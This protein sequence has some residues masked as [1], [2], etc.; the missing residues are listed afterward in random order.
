MR[1]RTK[2][3]DGDLQVD[4]AIVFRRR[5]V[6]VSKID[7]QRGYDELRHTQTGI[8]LRSPLNKLLLGRVG[9]QLLVLGLLLS[10]G[11]FVLELTSAGLIIV[12]NK[13][14]RLIRQRV[15]LLDAGVQ[16]VRRSTGEIASGRSH[17]GHEHSIAGEDS[18]S[19][20]VAD[21]SWG[22]A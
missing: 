9:R 5:H 21:A 7:L 2:N 14:P 4:G 10:N 8:A 16:I 3:I 6:S 15:K 17:I 12:S 13:H 20:H 22:V 18:I 1:I 11:R 19:N